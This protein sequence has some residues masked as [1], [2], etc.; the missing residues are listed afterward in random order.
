[1]IQ[2]YLH[3]LRLWW[4]LVAAAAL[5]AGIVSYGIASSSSPSYTATTTILVTVSTSTGSVVLD[6]ILV[7]ERLANTY[8]Q[9]IKTRPVL[10]GAAAALGGPE[11]ASDLESQVTATSI[12]D[13]QLIRVT[14]SA[15]DSERAALI[16]NTV[17]EVFV[18]RINQTQVQPEGA[19]PTPAPEGGAAPEASGGS[20]EIV[21]QAEAPSAGGTS[22]MVQTVAG[23]LAGASL[24]LIVI[25]GRAYFDEAI[26][27]PDDVRAAG[28][29]LPCLGTIDLGEIGGRTMLTDG[30]GIPMLS[31]QCRTVAATVFSALAHAR[32]GENG[33][34]SVAVVSSNRGEGRTSLVAQLGVAAALEERETVLVDFDLP[35]PQLHS[36]FKV[37]NR[38]G[39]TDVLWSAAKKPKPITDAL[40]GVMDGLRVV[41]AGQTSASTMSFN[42]AEIAAALEPLRATNPSLMFFDTSPMTEG[43]DAVLLGEI[44]D[45]AI[46]VVEAR[47]TT[48]ETLAALGS[49]MEALGL[50]V[51][52]Y[53]LNKA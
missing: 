34:M 47:K 37:P 52:G 23:M 48:T 16:A 22:K 11:T 32:P 3:H 1:V 14:A 24:M 50:T 29:H 13:S 53:I 38:F 51:L 5:I 31:Q 21:E 35:N 20:L 15:D 40:V 49:Q 25:A 44:L 27:R 36:E 43:G 18:Q 41:P 19:T 39:V 26:W 46:I 7:A 45:A 33:T 9:L 17:A 4:W 28:I 42:G 8:T 30:K 12:P 2:R 10:E 6:D